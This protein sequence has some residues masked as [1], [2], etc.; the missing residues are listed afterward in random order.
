MNPFIVLEGPDGSGKS[1]QAQRLA[2]HLR[3]GGIEVLLTREPGGTGISNQVRQILMNLENTAM[4]PTT[5][6]L[7]FSAARAQHVH[8]LIQ[9]HLKLGGTVVCDRYYQSTLAYQGYGHGLDLQTLTQIT[10]FATGGLD[11][12]L[13]LLLDIPAEEG[14]L[15]RRT[16][17]DWNRL[18]A[19]D[20]DFHR[21]VRTGYLN[22]AAANAH[23]WE[24]VNANQDPDDVEQVLWKIVSTRYQLA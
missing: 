22:M 11:P 17:G 7:L 15:R 4:H 21:R 2:K 14:L 3:A 8:E 24:I 16:G 23:F 9:P 20:L 6:I 10:Q 1:T 13:V 19:Y 12:D 18:D 5:E